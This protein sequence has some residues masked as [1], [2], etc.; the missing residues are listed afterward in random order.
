MKIVEIKDRN[1]LLIE[2]LVNVWEDLL[3]KTHLFLSDLEIE[4]IKRYVPQALLGV[5]NLIVLEDEKEDIAAF[6]GIE[7]Q[8][9]EMLFVASKKQNKGLGKKLVCYGIT[10]YSINELFV[11]EQNPLAKGFYEHIGFR[12]YK[13]SDSDEQGNP[14]PI[15]YRKLAQIG[16]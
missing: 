7:N 3:R 4:N 2:R 10:K 5:S 12:V 15:L 11:N 9:I 1:P 16:D 8:K 6:M 13:R 14:Y